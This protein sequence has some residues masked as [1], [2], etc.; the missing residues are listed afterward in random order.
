MRGNPPQIGLLSW[1]ETT[2]PDYNT[3][4]PHAS[5]G[6]RPLAPEV[7]LPAFGA[8]PGCATPTG[9]A[10]TLAQ[11]PTLTNIP[12]GPLSGGLISMNI[13]T[14]VWN[15]VAEATPRHRMPPRYGDASLRHAAYAM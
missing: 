6:Y 15:C 11:R 2:A 13:G 10:A 3:I 14:F 5:L 12:T 7:F 9:S 1:P 8:W 4:R